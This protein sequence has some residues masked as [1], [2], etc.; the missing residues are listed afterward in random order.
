M[1]SV[2]GTQGYAEE[3]DELFQRYES[4]SFAEVHRSVLHLIPTPPCRVL[5]IGSGT[6]RDAAALAAMGHRVVAVEPTAEMRTRAAALHSSPHIEWLDDS[7]PDLAQVTQL[8]GQFQ[9]VML[10]AVWMHLDEPQRRR[11]M[12]RVAS[13]VRMGGRISM[14]LRHGPTPLGRRMFDVSA[15]ETIARA[16]AEGL[17]CLFNQERTPALKTPDASWTRLVFA[18]PSDS[19]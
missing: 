17:R 6:G 13:L 2:S 10:T 18:K 15:N 4:T 3:A 12:P 1:R 9:L 11:A 16:E 14:T 7:L 8:G 5:D 19:A